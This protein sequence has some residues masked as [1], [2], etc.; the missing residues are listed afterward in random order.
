MEALGSAIASIAGRLDGV[1]GSIVQALPADAYAAHGRTRL[2]GSLKGSAD[3]VSHTALRLAHLAALLSDEA[4]QL[5][6][7]QAGW[8]ADERDRRAREQADE[9]R[10][11]AAARHA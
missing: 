4:D 3:L 10:R 2:N 6:R 11:T 5:R 7:D 9:D 8:D 1:G